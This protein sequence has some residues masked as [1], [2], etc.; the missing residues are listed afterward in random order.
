MGRLVSMVSGI[1]ALLRHRDRAAL[2]TG[3]AEAFEAAARRGTPTGEAV[4]ARVSRARSRSLLGRT[5]KDF[6]TRNV[7][8]LEYLGF[9]RYSEDIGRNLEKPGLSKLQSQ[10][11]SFNQ[12]RYKVFDAS[13]DLAVEVM[14]GL[15]RRRFSEQALDQ[16]V[17]LAARL[18]ALQPLEP[19]SSLPPDIARLPADGIR[20]WL[21]DVTAK[22]L[23]QQLA[24]VTSDVVGAIESPRS[25]KRHA[26]EL[27]SGGTLSPGARQFTIRVRT[28]KGMLEE[29]LL[30]MYTDAEIGQTRYAGRALAAS[31]VR[32]ARLTGRRDIEHRLRE[33][34]AAHGLSLDNFLG[35]TIEVTDKRGAKRRI[36]VRS[37]DFVSERGKGRVAAEITFGVRPNWRAWNRA[38]KDGLLGSYFALWANPKKGPKLVAGQPVRNAM[39]RVMSALKRWVAGWPAMRRGYS[40]VGMARLQADPASGVGMLWIL[41]N[42]PNAEEG[43]IRKIGFVEQFAMNGPHMRLGLSRFDAKRVFDAFHSQAE[44]R[45][46]EDSYP[47]EDGAWRADVTPQE[48]DRLLRIPKSRAAELLRELNERAV[49]QIEAMMTRLGVGFAYGFSNELWRAYCSA[50]MMLAHRLASA[51]EIQSYFDGWHPIVRVMKAFGSDTAKDQEMDGRIIWPGSLFVDPKIAKHEQVTFPAFKKIGKISD[52]FTM[53]AYLEMDPALT[54]ALGALLERSGEGSIEPDADILARRVRA[55]LAGAR[56]K[57]KRRDEAGPRSGSQESAGYSRGLEDLIAEFEEE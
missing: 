21:I 16:T 20:Q 48:Y 47:A 36:R 28:I 56:E 1:P 26:A 51:F 46:Y 4:P 10:V 57:S 54:Q 40:H 41:D 27:R 44:K 11:L 17:E 55:H 14:A 12:R 34:V 35:D 6:R 37:G 23:G 24:A 33:R 50:T 9:E 30:T 49:R 2:K 53:P 13:R 39:K 31:L 18:L 52:P 7:K 29:I 5:T 19:P 32:Y 38:R 43:G 15:R 42:Y 45:G 25:I 22:K 3:A 8:F